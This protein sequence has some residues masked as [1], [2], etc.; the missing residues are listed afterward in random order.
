MCSYQTYIHRHENHWPEPN[1]FEPERFLE[2]NL[3]SL[4]RNV[5]LPFGLGPRKCPGA[6]FAQQ[7]AILI[8]AEL[9][10]R[11]NFFPVKNH[12]PNLIGFLTLRTN[13]GIYINISPR[14]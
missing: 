1:K 12:I 8:L 9:I 3:E 13:N 11:Y 5:F 7:E 4:R 10:R 6:S 14:I 2:S